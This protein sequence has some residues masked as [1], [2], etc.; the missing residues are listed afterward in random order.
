ME[1]KFE[2]LS[3][4]YHISYGKRVIGT[5]PFP[6]HLHDGYEIYFACTGARQFII[7]GTAY[8]IND[9]DIFIIPPLTAH[10]LCPEAGKTYERYIVHVEPRGLAFLDSVIEINSHLFEL[11]N[12][13]GIE[14]R[15]KIMLDPQE[16][17]QYRELLHRT[18]FASKE[19]TYTVALLQFSG[20]IEFLTLLSEKLY[21][22]FYSERIQFMQNP[23]QSDVISRAME[24]IEDHLSEPIIIDDLCTYLYISQSALYK[25]FKNVLGITTK[26]YI[27]HRKVERAKQL[28][29][30]GDNVKTVA[31]K[32]GFNDYTNFIRIFSGEVGMPPKKFQM[33]SKT[34]F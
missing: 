23:V 29:Q 5:E 4:M 31:E 13:N 15:Y 11:F 18:Y 33:V 20:I 9:N 24:Y 16:S 17:C 25:G 26:K 14:K 12:I 7:N 1:Q 19:L 2:D 3:Q 32:C 6:S 27:I 28:L 22:S 21:R 10:N 34:S 8:S 30:E